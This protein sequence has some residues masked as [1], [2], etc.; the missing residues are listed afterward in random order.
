MATERRADR[1]PETRI[2]PVIKRYVETGGPKEWRHKET[3]KWAYRMYDLVRFTWFSPKD[4]SQLT[5]P[6]AALAVGP[7]GVKTLAA[8]RLSYNPN[9]I[10]YEITLGEEHID[11]SLWELTESLVH[12]TIHLYLDHLTKKKRAD[13][14]MTCGNL[15][16]GKSF[17]A[18][19]EEIGLHPVPGKGW[20][21]KPGDGPFERW[22][23]LLGIEK[24]EKA[25][26]KEWPLEP[27]KGIK[28]DWGEFGKP[29][30]RSSLIA[31]VCEVCIRK[32]E[33]KPRSGLKDLDLN[34][35]QCGGH[36]APVLD[37]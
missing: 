18:I 15:H 31:Y 37:F 14:L 13:K 23:D 16:H 9:G 32:P 33:C 10:L 22:M 19:A 26:G 12:E 27:P 2:N 35:G 6:Q 11:R 34:C 28:W 1:E 3:L 5:L 36:F 24:P 20:H 17:C 4:E 29:K 7:L 21:Y 25:Q 30:G 8:Y